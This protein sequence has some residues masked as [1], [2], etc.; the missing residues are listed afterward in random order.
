MLLLDELKGG[1]TGALLY[2]VSV[3]PAGARKVRHLVLK[4]DHI[5]KRD[6]PDESGRHLPKEEAGI[7]GFGDTPLGSSTAA[8]R[9]AWTLI[10]DSPLETSP[11]WE[12]T[13]EFEDSLKIGGLPEQPWTLAPLGVVVEARPT[14]TASPRAP[15]A[16][17]VCIYSIH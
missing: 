10:K 6:A 5:P 17:T 7:R 8:S 16:P 11:A 15:G 4:L 2:L 9:G 3:A 1:R 13:E 12:L 14:A